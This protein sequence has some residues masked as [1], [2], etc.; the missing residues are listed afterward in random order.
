MVKRSNTKHLAGP[1]L[2]GSLFQLERAL[3]HLASADVDSVGVEH[4]DDVSSFRDDRIVVQE[5]DKHI[6]NKDAEI[7]G[8]RS[9]ALW[10]TLQIWVGQR[11]AGSM[12][13]RYLLASG[14]NLTS[15]S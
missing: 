12:C 13:G 3:C 1:S 2:A 11:R 15:E 8:D 14:A 9:H 7:V 4:V 6:V 10:R 5:Q